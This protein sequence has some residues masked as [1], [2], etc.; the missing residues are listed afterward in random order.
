MGIGGMDGKDGVKQTRSV[1]GPV[2]L[3]VC[4]GCAQGVLRV[5]SLILTILDRQ[6]FRNL[7][8]FGKRSMLAKVGRIF[9][10]L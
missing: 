1:A 9:E 7:R 10:C 2:L 3:R 8:H 4:S 6:G 5:R